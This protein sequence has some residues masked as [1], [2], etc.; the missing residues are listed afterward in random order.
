MSSHHTLGFD[1][2]QYVKENSYPLDFTDYSKIGLELRCIDDRASGSEDKERHIAIPGA[3]LGLVMDV[4]GAFTLLRRKGKHATLRPQEAVSL[5]E[6]TIGSILFHTDDHHE[7]HGSLCAGCGHAHG[8]LTEPTPYLLTEEDAKYFFEYCL[9]DLKD[10][11]HVRGLKPVVYKGPHSA[12]AVM[13]VEGTDIGLSSI[14]RSGDAVFVYHK[15]FH[16]LLLKLIA[17]EIAPLLSEHT[18]GISEQEIEESIQESARI[19]LGVT[20]KKLAAALPKFEVRRDQA[21]FVKKLD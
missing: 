17:H 14:G 5:V 2:E 15:T 1:A 20:V 19:R 8:A 13:I 21:L 9:I 6:K 3:G 7:G 11:L 10:K 18:Q 4:L 12:K 16:E